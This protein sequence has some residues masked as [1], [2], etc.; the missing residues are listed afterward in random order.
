MWSTG[1]GR[2]VRKEITFTS[3]EWEDARAL[4]KKCTEGL[5]NYARYG[6]FARAM[7]TQGEVKVTVKHPLTDPEPIAAAIGRIGVN[8]NQI[9]HWANQNQSISV[10]QVAEVKTAFRQVEALL[11]QLFDEARTTREKSE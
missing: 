8:V 3:K 5:P 10:D 11:H 2:S 4:H 1:R 6:D 9:A 7:L